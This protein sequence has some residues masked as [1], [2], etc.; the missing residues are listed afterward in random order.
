MNTSARCE[1][2]LDS[3]VPHRTARART[4]ATTVASECTASVERLLAVLLESESSGRYR[5]TSRW[6]GP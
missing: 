1:P 6:L 4:R 3:H 5:T 2:S